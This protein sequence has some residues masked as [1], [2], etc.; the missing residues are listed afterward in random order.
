MYMGVVVLVSILHFTKSFTPIL[1]EIEEENDIHDINKD[2]HLFEG[3]IM[4]D[5]HT[6]RRFARSA[7][8][9]RKHLWDI[10]VPYKLEEN[11]GLRAKGVMMQAFEQF[12]L[13]SCIDFKPRKSEEYYISARKN[14]GCYSFV[15]KMVKGG[16]VLSIGRG[17]DHLG[18]IEHELL[19]LLGFHHEQS[20]YDRDKYIAIIWD[21][22]S[23]KHKGNFE[24]IPPD[25]ISSNSPYD[26]TS[27]MHYSKFAFSKHSSLTIYTKQ[28]QYQN[29]IG[30][31]MGMSPINVHRLNYL[32]NCG[33]SIS[34]LEHC[35]FA[36]DSMCGMSYCAKGFLGG[37]KRVTAVAGG[38]STDHTSLGKAG[39]Y[40]MHASTASG[41]KGHSAWLETKRMTPSRKCHV[42]CMQFYYY[43]SGSKTDR[44]NI[45]IREYQDEKDTKGKLRLMGQITGSPTS[46]WQFHQVSL[47]AAKPFQVVFEVRKGSDKSS[48]GFSIDD[49]NLSQTECPHHVWQIKDFEKLL[50]TTDF[51]TYMFGPVMYSHKGYAFQLVIA[52]RETF[53][54]VYV[55]LISG[56][57]D[58]T[59]EWPCPWRLVTI[60]ILDQNPHGQ[61]QMSKQTTILTDP[62]RDDFDNPRVVGRR[63]TINGKSVHVNS[64]I[65]MKSLLTLAQ[66][67]DRDFLK[68]G[69]AIFLVSIKDISSLQTESTLPC[70]KSPSAIS[71]THSTGYD[72]GPCQKGL[73]TKA[74]SS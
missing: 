13:K 46:H 68:G 23:Q 26:Y 17:C 10:P 64:S 5:I 66:I 52:L 30:Q 71:D 48:G 2:L 40:F 15:S 60:S 25:S 63:K 49:I 50:T 9:G 33:A 42:Q 51:E 24:K 44:L 36:Q 37:W 1:R 54:G 4:Q 61:K 53:F 27:I 55:H 8:L 19:H 31:R 16:Q 69:T 41:E 12:R 65:G 28:Q 7:T 29:K 73:K 6:R 47:N 35:D 57:H 59:L 22:I 18:T 32:Y 39:G 74:A 58:S 72:Q 62:T 34:F 70:P 21:S 38:P 43:H 45:W 67:K 3:D 11:L 56:D 20:R 14:R